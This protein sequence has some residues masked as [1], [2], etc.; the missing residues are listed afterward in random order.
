MTL[1]PTGMVCVCLFCSLLYKRWT[2][3]LNDLIDF[4]K[5]GKPPNFDDVVAK[6]NFYSK[7]YLIYCTIG[8]IV[9]S[10]NTLATA[11]ECRKVQAQTD[12]YLF[13]G[14]FLPTWLP[15]HIDSRIIFALQFGL[16][17]FIV[18]P[19]A[20]LYYIYCEATEFI[21]SHM[22]NLKSH[23]HGVFEEP[24]QATRVE[25]L[26]FCLGYHHHIMG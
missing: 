26:R 25:K 22:D 14:S 16:S 19:S 9:Y 10:I 3:F 17:Q 11:A 13:C 20:S 8:M 1:T 24:D 21:I 23:I 12:D 5:F 2:G 4:R 6:G 18:S 7:I 15:Y